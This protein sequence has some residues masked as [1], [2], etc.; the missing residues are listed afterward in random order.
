M[1]IRPIRNDD[2]LAAA[3]AR[4]DALWGAASGTPEGDELDVWMTLIEAYER[5]HHALPPG[6]P[7]EVIAYKMGELGFSGRKLA[8]LLGWGAGRVSEV[9]NRKRA[10]TL[11]MVQQL[12]GVLGIDPSRLVGAEVPAA[13]GQGWVFIAPDLLARVRERAARDEAEDVDAWVARTLERALCAGD[14]VVATFTGPAPEPSA[15]VA[16]PCTLRVVSALGEGFQ[17]AA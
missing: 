10:L 1:T 2:D 13:A 8:S 9:L 17:E 11:A 5:A 4:V 14:P 3:F 6:D 7:I 16:P 15:C 12:A